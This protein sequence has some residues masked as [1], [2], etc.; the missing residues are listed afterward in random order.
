MSASKEEIE[1]PENGFKSLAEMD[2]YILTK[3]VGKQMAAEIM[4]EAAMTHKFF[5]EVENDIRDS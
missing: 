3:M 2:M 4:H 5:T 1:M